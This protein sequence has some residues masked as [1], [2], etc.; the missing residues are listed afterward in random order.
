MVRKD[1]KITVVHGGISSEREVSL[2]SGRAVY[3]ALLRGGFTNVTLFDLTRESMGE[4]LS[5]DM[6]LAYL[7]L[8]GKGG[9][10][11]CIQGM[12][13]LA[14]IPY[15]GSD[16]EAS[17]CCMDKIRTKELL[18]RAGLPTPKFLKL[19]AAECSDT[20]GTARLI[21]DVLGLPAV[22][23]SPCEGSSI[24]VFIVKNAEELEGCIGEI[25][26]YGDMLLAEEFMDGTEIT[27]P[28]LGNSDL[29]VLTP[30]EITSENEFYDYES[31]YTEGMCRHIIPARISEADCENVKT[32]GE[33]A[34]KCLGCAGLSRIDF[35]IDK[36]KG[37]MI[38]EI[39]TLPG[40]TEMS[41]FPDSARYEG[42]S[43]PELTEKVV[44]YALEKFKVERENK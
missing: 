16:V 1:L 17:A 6:E 27:L 14:G 39:N 29:R 41:L 11:G 36:E 2:R 44:G 31:K 28:I 38:I 35:I 22:L 5:M 25:F 19:S 3:E 24:G 33:R 23:K 7:A 12:L 21:I 9:E 18:L 13:E 43:F 26:K 34:Y 8:H 37:P 30:I 4:L 20:V 40:M 42:I 32:I 10:D 15:T